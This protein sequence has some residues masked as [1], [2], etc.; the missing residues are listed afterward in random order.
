MSSRPASTT[1][2]HLAT[3]ARPVAQTAYQI[4]GNKAPLMVDREP[5]T[6]RSC[7]VDLEATLG[8]M[9]SGM[10][11]AWAKGALLSSD[12][13]WPKSDPRWTN[14]GVLEVERE[15]EYGEIVRVRITVEVL[16]P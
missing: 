1:R 9:S 14:E 13:G 5:V 3:E 11:A 8:A 2:L 15:N 7:A 12:H 4:M 10:P 6:A 16:E